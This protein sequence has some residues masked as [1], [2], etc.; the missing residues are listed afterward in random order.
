MAENP[1]KLQ[2]DGVDDLYDEWE[3]AEEDYDNAFDEMIASAGVMVA[4]CATASFLPFLAP[5]CAAATS[6]TAFLTA[7]STRAR[8]ARDR[9]SDKLRDAYEDWKKCVENHKWYYKHNFPLP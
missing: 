3:D 9:A 4:L 8:G 7:K 2:A 5:P 6:T 1:C